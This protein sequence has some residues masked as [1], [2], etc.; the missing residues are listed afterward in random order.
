VKITRRQQRRITRVTIE[1][2]QLIDRARRF[3][4]RPAVTYRIPRYQEGKRSS[5][6]PTGP[7]DFTTLRVHDGQL[8][9]A[10]PA[11]VRRPADWARVRAARAA[12]MR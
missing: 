8:L 5:G 6:T 7:S 10:D 4:R 3:Q 12:R 1:R 11:P 2:R 9:P